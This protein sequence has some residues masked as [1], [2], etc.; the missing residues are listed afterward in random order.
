MHEAA[1]QELQD[2][3]NWIREFQY[4]PGGSKGQA[5]SLENMC[6]KTLNREPEEPC[7]QYSVLDCFREGHVFNVGGEFNS[8][9]KAIYSVRKSYKG[10]NISE[11]FTVEYIKQHCVQWTN[12]AAAPSMILGGITKG[13][14]SKNQE[15]VAGVKALRIA[16]GTKAPETLVEEGLIYTKYK[17]ADAVKEEEGTYCP[18]VENCV[19]CIEGLDLDI[20]ARAGCIPAPVQQPDSCCELM[21]ALRRSPCIETLFQTKPDV[22]A[23]GNLVLSACSLPTVEVENRCRSEE[24]VPG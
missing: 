10:F 7:F 19:E 14:N 23:L 18:H 3:Q 22:K 16:F 4:L 5:V 17:P 21:E 13:V 15:T 2:L 20:A 11:D 1:L 24:Y 6:Y 12:V 9:Y 8:K